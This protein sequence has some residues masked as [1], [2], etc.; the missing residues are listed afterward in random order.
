MNSHRH[1]GN[2]AVF[3]GP[4]D[5]NCFIC[6]SIAANACGP[7]EDDAV[8]ACGCSGYDERCAVYLKHYG[9]I[10]QVPESHTCCKI[11][12]RG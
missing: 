4:P 2:N 7:T 1:F 6:K 10:T 3:S 12:G 8:C 5:P 9:H 11:P